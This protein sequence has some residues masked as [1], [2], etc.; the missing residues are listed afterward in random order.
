MRTAPPDWE[1]DD[2]SVGFDTD[3]TQSL[4]SE[5]E[6]SA[7]LSPTESDDA[8]LPDSPDEDDADAD[9]ESDCT[10]VPDEIP[11]EAFGFETIEEPAAPPVSDG[12]GPLIDLGEGAGL[13]DE[14][15][16]C[17]SN[18]PELWQSVSLSCTSPY[19]FVS[20]AT[21]TPASVS[22]YAAEP[23]VKEVDV[24][25]HSS[26]HCRGART[27]NRFKA[28]PNV[29]TLRLFVQYT[30]A[31]PTLHS[32]GEGTLCSALCGFAPSTVVLRGMS[33]VYDEF[34]L[35]LWVPRVLEKLKRLVLVLE[36]GPTGQQWRKHANVAPPTDMANAGIVPVLRAM[37]RLKLTIVFNSEPGEMWDSGCNP[38]VLIALGHLLANVSRPATIV[39][40]ESLTPHPVL[41][42]EQQVETLL[43]LERMKYTLNRTILERE[44]HAPLP[45]YMSM[46][47]WMT[48][49]TLLGA[50]VL[51]E[52]N[53]ERWGKENVWEHMRPHSRR[54]FAAEAKMRKAQA[55]HQP[56]NPEQALTELPDLTSDEGRESEASAGSS[57]EA[58]SDASAEVQGGA[59]N[60]ELAE[61]A[62]PGAPGEEAPPKSGSADPAPAPPPADHPRRP[63]VQHGFA[64]PTPPSPVPRCDTTGLR[65][66][67]RDDPRH[68]PG[69]ASW[70][71]ISGSPASAQWA[72]RQLL[73][74]DDP[75]RP[76]HVKS[77]LVY[78]TGGSNTEKF[79]IAS[80]PRL[81]R[82]REHPE[83]QSVCRTHDPE[84]VARLK[85]HGWSVTC[86]PAPKIPVK[87]VQRLT[88]D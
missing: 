88:I 49:R 16:A 63:I 18:W 59:T 21:T 14:R 84:A 78:T 20:D 44:R 39:N 74:Q 9:A 56:P 43:Y 33:L 34:P 23:H 38:V 66:V 79:S 60:E 10:A 69:P 86:N 36:P 57:A 75:R 19:G 52:G 11:D 51:E 24:Q 15:L 80:P 30:D 29:E 17:E 25:P 73:S 85:E 53:V 48:Q 27:E 7:D 82:M 54:F 3:D 47:F 41:E 31:G 87:D 71:Y 12:G 2:D 5:W 76:P 70:V 45:S 81:D 64:V 65:I 40:L 46:G 72:I 6:A 37:R 58:S 4:D 50:K 22:A 8:N 42:L 28:L 35:E 26:A 62:G 77:P 1:T 67:A 83:G 55:S 32:P 68:P 13:S 61:P